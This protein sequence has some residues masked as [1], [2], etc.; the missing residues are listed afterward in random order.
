MRRFESA[1]EPSFEGGNQI[2]LLQ[3]GDALFPALIAAIDAAQREV[4]LATYIFYADEAAE[5]IARALAAAA[6]RGVSVMVAVDGFGSHNTL[7]TV[8]GWLLPHGVKLVVFRPLTRW[9]NWLQPG[10]MRRLHQKLC[11][12]DSQRAF[13]GGINLIDDRNDLTHGRDDSPRLDFAVSLSGPIVAPI[14]QTVR[15]VW[16][17]ASLGQ[18]WRHEV[19]QLARSAEPLQA[20]RRL[21]RRVRILP[22]PAELPASAEPVQ[23]AFL[24]RDN[25][26]QRRSIERALIAAI[27]RSR[28]RVDLVTPYFYP[29][30]AFRRALTNAAR[31]GARVRLLLQ[32]KIDY[33][34]AGLAARVLYDELLAHGVEIYEYTPAFLHAKMALADDAWV[35]VGSSNIDPLSLLLNLEANVVVADAGF[36]AEANLAFEAALAVSQRITVSPLP[37]GVVAFLG[38]TLVSWIAHWYLRVAGLSE[39][40]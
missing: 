22:A 5:R 18:G 16:T 4:W 35:T 19:A 34:L 23:V 20:A 37:P 13:V 30:W 40:Y 14:E 17:R 9:W 29:G 25:L 3:G 39:R 12:V 2:A 8:S 11:V 7:G 28:R 24:V 38:R 33:R 36:S 15:A 10:Q 31:R 1:A 6:R 26:R 32:G 27:R 21:L